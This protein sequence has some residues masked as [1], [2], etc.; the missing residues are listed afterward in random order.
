M[1]ATGRFTA[2]PPVAITAPCAATRMTQG[3]QPCTRAAEKLINAQ[4]HGLGCISVWWSDKLSPMRLRLHSPGA[5]I[6]VPYA[7]SP[8]VG[9][10]FANISCC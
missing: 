4:R 3:S 5:L 9:P 2:R 7:T 6:S 10:D 1:T 8:G